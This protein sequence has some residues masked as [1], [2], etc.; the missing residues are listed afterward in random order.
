MDKLIFSKT[1]DNIKVS[2]IPN[3]L[4]AYSEPS[5][6]H[7]VWAYTVQVENLSDRQVQLLNRHWMITDAAGQV[8][9]VRGPGVV[10]EQPVL[11]PGE[12]FRYTSGT[13]LHTPSGMMVGSY[14]MSD[15]KG[16]RFPIEVPAFSLDSPYQIARPN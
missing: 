16:N 12:G 14:E 3:F 9:E 2:V 10:G 15:E 6:E 11:K 4:D 7:Y 13:A 1:T 5:E 8:E